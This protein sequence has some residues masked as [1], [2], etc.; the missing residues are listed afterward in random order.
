[1]HT[2]EDV[3]P[4]ET[5]EFGT[6]QMSRDEILEFATQY[7]PQ[8]FHLGDDHHAPYETV[9]AS[10]WHTAAVTMRMLVKEYLQDAETLGS[11]GLNG[12]RWETPVTPGDTLSVRLTFGE[13]EPWDE[14]RGIVTQEIETQ[15]GDDETVMWMEAEVLYSRDS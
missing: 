2:F 3:T 4:G 7:D 5:R 1:M 9:I 11:P 14:H 8:P 6:Y 15:N 12:L 13:T 10:G